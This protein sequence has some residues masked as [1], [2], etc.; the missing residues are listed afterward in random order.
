ME[1]RNVL[2]V[3]PTGGGKSLCYQ[4]PSLCPVSYT[5][6]RSVQVQLQK[7]IDNG[8]NW[9]NVGNAVSLAVDSAS[10]YATKSYT[11]E[12]P[13]TSGSATIQY[14]VIELAPDGSQLLPSDTASPEFTTSS[15]SDTFKFE[16]AYDQG[17]A[18]MGTDGTATQDVSIANTY[19][20]PTRE[21][22]SLKIA[23]NYLNA[24]GDD[25]ASFG[26]EV[27]LDFTGVDKNHESPTW[28]PDSG[29]VVAN[30]GSVTLEPQA[31]T[32]NTYAFNLANGQNV[33][34]EDLP[35]GT[36]ATVREVVPND[37]SYI[38]TYNTDNQAEQG[39]ITRTILNLSLIHI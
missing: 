14:R 11:W 29:N 27:A 25:A 37:Q 20:E 5:H 16:V 36:K 19:Q 26:F 22:G 24:A 39:G 12:R 28:V 33:T 23:K 13:R 18:A 34:L 38:V 15:G 31:G 35:A 3:M 30:T 8:A 7:S 6:L 17:E 9:S 2:V 21:Y 10:P 1:G 4:L 32:A